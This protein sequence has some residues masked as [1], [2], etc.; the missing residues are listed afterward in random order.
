MPQ[1]Q[2][3]FFLLFEVGLLS[4][5]CNTQPLSINFLCNDV[6]VG[7]PSG[8][9]GMAEEYGTPEAGKLPRVSTR[10]LRET[11]SRQRVSGAKSL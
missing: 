4:L 3:Q 8:D 5:V 11:E 9:G 10:G 7:Y 1:A 2:I 6:V